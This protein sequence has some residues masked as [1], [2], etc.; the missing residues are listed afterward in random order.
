MC[1]KDSRGDQKNGEKG[2]GT[3][4]FLLQSLNL[5]DIIERCQISYESFRDSFRITCGLPFT[6]ITS[7]STSYTVRM[8]SLVITSEGVSTA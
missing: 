6:H 1:I 7:A 4:G 3:A 2:S 5:G 8:F